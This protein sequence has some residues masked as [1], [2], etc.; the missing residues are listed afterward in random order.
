ML[1]MARDVSRILD[2]KIQIGVGR[3]CTENYHNLKINSDAQNVNTNLVTI[4]R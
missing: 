3:G 2:Y 1:R 4:N